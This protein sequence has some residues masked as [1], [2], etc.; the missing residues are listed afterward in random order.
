MGESRVELAC[1]ELAGRTYAIDVLQVRE[2]VRAQAV[3]PLPCAPTLIEGVVDLRGAIVPV[4]DLGRALGLEPVGEPTRARIAVLEVEGL[5]FGLRVD[6]AVDVLSLQAEDL[7]AP[8]ELAL[9]AG[10][11]A[12]RALVRREGSAPVLVLSLEHLLE[13]IYRS[14]QKPVEEAP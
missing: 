6:A 12:V 3:T 1:L 7:E 8:P 10:Y 13:S 4:V 14:A 11:G 5:R 2:I 9:Q